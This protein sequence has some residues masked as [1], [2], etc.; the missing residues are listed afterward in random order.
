MARIAADVPAN[1]K[2]LEGHFPGDPIVPGVAQIVALAEGQARRV[3][4]DLAYARGLKRVKF[5][6][7]LRVDD[8]LEVV[9]TRAEGSSD[10]RFEIVRGDETCSKG[11][12][13]FS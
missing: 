13:L 4:T 10:V 2:Y 8:S 12:L 11:T 3:W 7:A 9:L 1:L 6:A 5:M